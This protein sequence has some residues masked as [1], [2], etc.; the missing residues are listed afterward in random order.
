VATLIVRNLEQAVKERLLRRA[1]RN[2]R[3]LDEEV[4]AILRKAADLEDARVL[5]LGTRIRARF[6]NIG[7]ARPIPE[8]R[9][10]RLRVPRFNN[11]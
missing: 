5:P 1:K 10:G 6:E 8:L 3:S 9:G 11:D 4:R 2:G 7:L